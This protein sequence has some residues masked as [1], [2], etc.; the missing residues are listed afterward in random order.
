MWFLKKCFLCLSYVKIHMSKLM[1][2]TAPT[3]HNGTKVKTKPVHTSLHGK[4]YR[5]KIFSSW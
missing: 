2:V 4:C 5:A 3:E 1:H